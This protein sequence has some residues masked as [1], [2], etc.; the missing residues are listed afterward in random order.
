MKNLIKYL[1]S[2]ISNIRKNKGIQIETN[3]TVHKRTMPTSGFGG[4]KTATASLIY[5]IKDRKIELF[6][7]RKSY[8]SNF[9][10]DST[11]LDMEWL[12]AEQV[13]IL[14]ETDLIREIIAGTYGIE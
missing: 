14:F 1:N 4:L 10:E 8:S 7:I 9:E 11:W 13:F 2:Y 6:T 3:L 12:F 5:T